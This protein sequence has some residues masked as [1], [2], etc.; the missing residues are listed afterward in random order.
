MNLFK[1]LIFTL[2]SILYATSSFAGQKVT[3][4]VYE[5]RNGNGTR[6]QGEPGISGV[7][8]SNQID[9]VQT[10]TKGRFNLAVTERT[11]IFITK[12]PGYQIPLNKKNL[13]QFYYLHFPDGSP[14]T[15][16]FAGI[17]PTGKLPE[18]LNFPLKKTSKLKQFTA[19]I[20]G[21]PQPATNTH[22]DYFRD[23]IIADMLGEKASFYLAL[24]DIVWDDLSLYGRYN[25]AVSQL[26]I[27][28]YNVH[29]NHDM[30]FNSPNDE[31]AAETF[32]RI[33]GPEY[34]SFEYGD[35]H[36]I[37]L[38]DVNYQGWNEQENRR[39]SYTGFLSDKQLVWLEN[40]LKLVPENKLI[41]LAKHIPIATDLTDS[42]SNNIT[43]RD[44]LFKILKKRKKLLAL[45][46]HT[47]CTEAI[48]L[49]EQHGWTGTNAFWNIN[50]GAA[51]GAW[52]SGP[53]D[54]RGL[55][56]ALGK[57]G[58]PNGYYIFE[59]DGMNY[60]YRF[61]AANQQKNRQIRVSAPSGIIQQN[62][63]LEIKI[64]ANIFVGDAETEVN[65]QVDDRA[66]LPMVNQKIQD[67]FVA[68][69]VEKYPDSVNGWI[70]SPQISTHIWQ[71]DLPKDLAGGMH[72]LKISARDHQGKI[73]H[74][75]IVFE[76]AQ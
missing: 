49:G 19:I 51:C 50:P 62:D 61:Q 29:G 16:K 57:D 76:I 63:T 36:F 33:F 55:P 58:S 46:G 42:P 66:V 12:P 23:D 13:P 30:N 65:C 17:A 68:D 26:K 67:P 20:T 3:G 21:D 10:D 54:I 18:S 43:N 24:G 70:R 22:V 71:A 27:P 38:D 41:V 34:Y 31:F 9:V 11:I 15:F 48:K 8:V 25:N 5:D 69:Y 64:I 74:E 73:Y 28:A 47:H 44:Q 56:A 40:D 35:V 52:W 32:R 59:F 7:A 60:S 53:K 6:D 39:G 45:C 72:T 37:M 4:I 14:K 1:L 75:S 2:L